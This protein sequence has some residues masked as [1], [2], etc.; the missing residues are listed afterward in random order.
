MFNLTIG[1]WGNRPSGEQHHPVPFLILIH[2]QL[3][4]AEL[5]KDYLQDLIRLVQGPVPKKPLPA[6]W[7]YFPCHAG[8]VGGVDNFID[9]YFDVEMKLHLQLKLIDLLPEALILPGVFPD[10]GVI[11][12]ASAFLLGVAVRILVACSPCNNVS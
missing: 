12:E 10:L 4:N 2:S 5:R 7:D 11:V 6:I 9:Y 1:A 8:A 3:F